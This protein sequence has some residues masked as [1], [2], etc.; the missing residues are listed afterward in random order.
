MSIYR[1]VDDMAILAISKKFDTNFA[2][3]S[4]PEIAI[5]WA[6][7]E[8]ITFKRAKSEL[9]HFSR[10]YKDKYPLNKLT[11]AHGNK[12]ESDLSSPLH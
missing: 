4:S 10:Y 6:D 1:Y 8:R 9:L 2:L 12:I 11:V 7:K 3:K 5:S